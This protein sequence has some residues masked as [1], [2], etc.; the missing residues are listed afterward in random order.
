MKA[1]RSL[2]VRPAIPDAIAGLDELAAN[3]RWSYHRPTRDLFEEIDPE[4][5]GRSGHDPRLVLARAPH[6]RLVELSQDPGYVARVQAEVDG[7]RAA[8]TSRSWFD[9]QVVDLGGAVAYF[10]PEF[11]I[12]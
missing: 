11:G 3:L 1:V 12:A 9:E 5:W 8:L 7:L 4:E 6:E 10:S 2:T